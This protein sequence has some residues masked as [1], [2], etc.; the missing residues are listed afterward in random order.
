MS[1]RSAAALCAFATLNRAL[2][3]SARAALQCM[4]PDHCASCDAP[5][6]SG[7]VFCVDCGPCPQ[8]GCGTL[9]DGIRVA[10]TYAP[11]LSTA[12]LR[13]KFGHRADLAY[14]LARL[15]P[16]NE[17]DVAPDT[18]VVPVPLHL[19]RLCERGF[20]PSALMARCF[21]KRAGAT[22]AP[23]LLERLRHTPH[24]SSL[25]ARERRTN[26]ARAFVVREAGAAGRHAVLVDDVVTTGSTIEACRRALYAAGVVHV[27]VVAL[28]RA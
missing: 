15:L 14:R 24:Q 17:G 6:R 28:A 4:A 13:M 8:L 16:L 12:I 25:P 20:N 7:A 11:P 23:R 19:L 18:L 10:G 1:R 21:A 26:V 3:S 22:F 5:V 9:Q 2:R 27:R